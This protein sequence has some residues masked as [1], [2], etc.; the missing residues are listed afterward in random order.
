MTHT[1]AILEVPNTVYAAVRALLKAFDYEHTFDRDENGEVIDMTGIA[2]RSK[3]GPCE[4]DIVITSLLSNRTKEGA[5]ELSLNGEIAQMDLDKAREVVGMLH[6]AIEA[7][8]TD[9]IV[10]RFVTEKLKAKPEVAAAVLLEIREQRQES[11][12][13]VRPN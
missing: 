7:A 5:V 3:G 9:Q 4:T 10:F 11:R 1:Y 8:I 6:S 12:D 2:L 13:V